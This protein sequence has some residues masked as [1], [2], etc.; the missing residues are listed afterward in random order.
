MILVRDKGGDLLSFRSI[1]DIDIAKLGTNTEIRISDGIRSNKRL[2]TGELLIILE[3]TTG[4]NTANISSNLASSNTSH[5][6]F[7]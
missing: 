4:F 6:L 3:G 7:I 5:F 2:G 1:A